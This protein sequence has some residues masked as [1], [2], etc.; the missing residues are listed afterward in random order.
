MPEPLR[1]LTI[2]DLEDDV[3]LVARALRAS[4]FAP[5]IERIDTAEAMTSALGDPG[6]D[7]IIA[8]Y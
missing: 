7:I 3:V 4:G 5:G 1:V 6:W 2:E 8:D